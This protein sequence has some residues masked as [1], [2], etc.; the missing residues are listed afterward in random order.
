M[1]GR[2]DDFTIRQTAATLGLANVVVGRGTGAVG[3][4]GLVGRRRLG[5]LEVPKEGSRDVPSVSRR[6]RRRRRGRKK[7]V[8]HVSDH[9]LLYVFRGRGWILWDRRDAGRG[10]LTR[11]GQTR[12]HRQQRWAARL[13]VVV[14]VVAVKVG[15]LGNRTD[16]GGGGGVVVVVIIPLGERRA[17]GGFRGTRCQG[18]RPLRALG[19]G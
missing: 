16:G 10:R 2:N 6:R 7:R 19:A 8:S 12:R 18:T 11:I 3:L 4:V 17:G 13:L 14:V 15:V 9:H 5:S 1:F